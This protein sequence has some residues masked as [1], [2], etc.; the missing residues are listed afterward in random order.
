MKRFVITILLLGSACPLLGQTKPVGARHHNVPTASSA[1]KLAEIKV[2]GTTKYT[3]ATIIATTGLKIG[4]NVTEENFKEA[5]QKLGE[6]GFFTHV[7][8]SYSFDR[9]GA[10]LEIQIADSD[11]LVPVDFDNLVW[12]PK[13]D[14]L[15]RIHQSIPLFQGEVPASGTLIDEIADLLS[16]MVAEKNPQLHLDYLRSGT[17]PN[18]AIVFSVSGTEI[19]I[20]GVEYPGASAARLPA[21]AAAS[22]KIEGAEFQSSTLSPFIKKELEPIYRKD[23]YLRVKF[24]EPHAQVLSEKPDE[25]SVNVKLPV[26]EGVQYRLGTIVFQ[27]NSVF[28]ADKLKTLIH[29]ESGQPLNEMQLNSDLEAIRRLYGT[30]G[31]VKAV[32]EPAAEF[33]EAQHAADYHITINEG[34]AY[35]MGELIL[36]GLD[37]KL[38]ARMREDW[39][40]REGTPYDSSYPQQFVKQATLDLAKDGRWSVAV[41]ES[42]DDKDSTVDVSLTFS[43]NQ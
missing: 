13:Q 2:T 21:L 14:L 18:H 43:K 16:V 27:G 6:T 29:A 7:A 11:K 19:R 23:G 1:H 35:K 36:D 28:P 31:H 20:Q 30:R 41:H 22:K 9:E 3:P 40:L 39:T 15:D 4:Q 10:R 32:V 42:V 17:G 26:T 38:T 34:P 8:Y 33:D 12:Y 25:T 5:V 24:G 37:D